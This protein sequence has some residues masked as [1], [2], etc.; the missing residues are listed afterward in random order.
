MSM[1]KCVSLLIAERDKSDGHVPG[2]G[3]VVLARIYVL[4][5]LGYL[6]KYYIVPKPK[7]NCHRV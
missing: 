4:F 1:L 2:G 6:I 3:F 7:K 5:P